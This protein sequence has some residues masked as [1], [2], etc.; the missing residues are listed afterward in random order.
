MAA[1]PDVHTPRSQ[2]AHPRRQEASLSSRVVRRLNR[3]FLEGQ[4][5]MSKYF[6][7]AIGSLSI[8]LITW[9][10]V[11][12][13][14]DRLTWDHWDVAKRGVIY[15]SGQLTADQLT[16]AVERYKLRTVVSLHLP[17]KRVEDERAL[18]K[19]L[20]VDFVN[21]PMPGDGFGE[22]PQFREFLKIV[23]DPA[24]RPVVVH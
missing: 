14:Q 18:A 3:H 15:R 7:A 17:G 24:R 16:Q 11:L 5:R 1:P 20:G 6:L 13:G 21:L 8:G 19:K 22:E 2:A 12:N 4:N 10:A 23:D 9:M